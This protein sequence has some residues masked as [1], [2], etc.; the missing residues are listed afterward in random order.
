MTIFPYRNSAQSMNFGTLIKTG[1]DQAVY[2]VDFADGI[3]TSITLSSAATVALDDAGNT[4]TSDCVNTTT[5][6][7]TV[8]TISMKTC[9][10]SGTGA[11]TTGDRFRLRTTATLST[12]ALV[13]D[14]FVIIEDATY[15]PL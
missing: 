2:K 14:V 1:L 9:G 10:A 15:A 8:A 11:A 6:S 4:V 5:T 12:G 13:F 3:N 7:G